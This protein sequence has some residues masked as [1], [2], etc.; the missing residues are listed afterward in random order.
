MTL[1]RVEDEGEGFVQRRYLRATGQNIQ[2]IEL[3]GHAEQRKS[4]VAFTSSMT[5]RSARSYQERV[6]TDSFLR[7]IV[8]SAPASNTLLPTPMSSASSTRNV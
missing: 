8:T 2:E 1:A 5:S 7:S 3:S 4:S 6:C